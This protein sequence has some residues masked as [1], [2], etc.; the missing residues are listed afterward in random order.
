MSETATSWG[1]AAELL[2]AAGVEEDV[3]YYRSFT[4]PDEKAVLSV[5]QRVQ[6]AWAANDGDVF[7]DCFSENGSLLMQDDQLTSREEIRSYMT[8][9][10]RGIYKGAH[11]TGYPLSLK[12][13]SDGVALAVTEGGIVLDGETEVAP[14]RRI[15]AT[16]VIVREGEGDLRLFSHQSSPING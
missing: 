10:F 9:G 5:A 15:R 14:Q 8:Q 16:W 7:A 12:F 3:D 4:S 6:A 11:V 2:A 1:N 13:L